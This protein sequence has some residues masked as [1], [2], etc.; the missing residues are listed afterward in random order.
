MLIVCALAT[1]LR[2]SGPAGAIDATE[3]LAG[4]YGANSTFREPP[5]QEFE[6]F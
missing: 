5:C 1:V 4:E 3:F 2:L 6:R